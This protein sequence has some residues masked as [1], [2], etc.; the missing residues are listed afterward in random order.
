MAGETRIKKEIEK[1]GQNKTPGI[2]VS[3]DKDNYRYF[4]IVIE[5]P[6]GTFPASFLPVFAPLPNSPSFRVVDSPYEKGTFKLEMFLDEDYPMGPPKV[7]FLTRVYHPVRP[8]RHSPQLPSHS[9]C[10][11]FR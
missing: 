8:S 11:P 5:G 7:R 3:V 2:S 6:K 1:L 10:L 9:L 4:S